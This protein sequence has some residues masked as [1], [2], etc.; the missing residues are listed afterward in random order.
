MVNVVPFE[1]V[2]ELMAGNGQSQRIPLYVTLTLYRAAVDH[3]LHW[4]RLIAS[5]L[6]GHW[7]TV[8]ITL[9]FSR[10]GHW[11]TRQSNPLPL[12]SQCIPALR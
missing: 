9:H 2:H 3:C 6:I 7:T 11:T 12:N 4:E 1:R 5:S 8:Y 10:I